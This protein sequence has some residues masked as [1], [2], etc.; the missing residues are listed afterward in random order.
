M[1]EQAK[2]ERVFAYPFGDIYSN[3][4][5]KVERKGR[6]REDLDDVLGW[7]TGY[8]PDEL[9]AAADSSESLRDF[10]DGLALN[11]NSDF[12]TGKVCGVRVEEVDDDL[13]RKIRQM[14]LLVDELARGKNIDNI[15]RG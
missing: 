7:F 10:F 3:Y 5:A 13:M 11:P 8:T 12:I 2:L 4:V 1:D 6:T 15:K 9:H 14:D